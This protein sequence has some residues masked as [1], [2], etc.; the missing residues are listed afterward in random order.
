[1][2]N[3]SAQATVA[4]AFAQALT[5]ALP[6]IND[7][8]AKKERAA[9]RDNAPKK[10]TLVSVEQAT[11]NRDAFQAA[12]AVAN[13]GALLGAFSAEHELSQDECRVAIE[14][15]L[16]ENMSV[17]TD[18]MFSRKH[19]VGMLYINNINQARNAAGM[20]DLAMG[21]QYNY[22]S[23]TKAFITARGAEPLDLF[24]NFAVA[25]Q[26]AEKALSGSKDK[27]VTKSTNKGAKETIPVGNN[28][29]V[30]FGE[31]AGVQPLLHFV[32]EWL[33]VNK[34]VPA[35][36]SFVKHVGDLQLMVTN[37]AKAQGIKV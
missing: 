12:T 22:M 19:E 32:N 4:S 11:A 33:A 14:N 10:D 2:S 23:R 17:L 21:S 6:V 20:A 26:A 3:T 15:L 5:N 8:V 34:G 24:G 31:L 25:K 27:K 7:P 30:E 1:M 36:E 37:I 35:L 13:A 29:A 18:D 9:K 16:R 28:N